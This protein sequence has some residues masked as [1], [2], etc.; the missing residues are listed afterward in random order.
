M[1]PDTLLFSLSLAL[2][3]MFAPTAMAQESGS[4]PLS[5][6]MQQP[7]NAT[8]ESATAQPTT[9]ALGD[10][11]ELS[12]KAWRIAVNPQYNLIDDDG[13]PKWKVGFSV[14]LLVPTK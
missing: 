11:N 2:W 5:S 1:N 13:L 7:S 9:G 12:R 6:G 3:V 10:A 4:P 8:R 14:T